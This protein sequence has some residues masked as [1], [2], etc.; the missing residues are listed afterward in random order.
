MP[1]ECNFLILLLPIAV[2]ESRYAGGWEKCRADF[3][4]KDASNSHQSRFLHDEHLLGIGAMN[5]NDIEELVSDWARLGFL[6]I[7]EENG[8]EV[9]K[10]MCVVDELFGP[11]LR[12][13]WINYDR[14]T[15]T[16]SIIS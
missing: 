11:T 15:R 3:G 6:G 16:A 2:I 14:K 8:E 7:V 9:W 10:E 5:P 1:I 13:D 12:C 4:F